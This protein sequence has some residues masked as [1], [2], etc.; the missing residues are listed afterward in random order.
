MPI[1]IRSAGDILDAARDAKKDAINAER[2]RREAGGFEYQGVFYDSDERSAKRILVAVSAAMAD[3][4]GF[5]IAWTAQD[6]ST[7]LLDGPAMIGLNA[8][9]AMHGN[10]LHE[11][12][13]SLKTQVEAA[14][15]KSEVDAVEWP[16]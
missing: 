7:H 4:E 15:S 5:Q 16:E 8:A 10:A 2:D 12:A 6:N 1:N 14:T 13:R 11:T 3:V 9:L